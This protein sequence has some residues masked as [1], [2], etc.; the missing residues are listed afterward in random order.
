MFFSLLFVKSKETNIAE[1][2]KLTGIAINEM[3][4]KIA[5]K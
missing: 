5:K 2:G 3:A 4:K 1:K